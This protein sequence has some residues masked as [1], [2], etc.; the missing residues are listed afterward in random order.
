MVLFESL[1]FFIYLETLLAFSGESIMVSDYFYA[2][3]F[4]LNLFKPCPVVPA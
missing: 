3:V 4:I 2:S 1:L